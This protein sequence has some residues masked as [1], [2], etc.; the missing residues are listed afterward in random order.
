MKKLKRTFLKVDE[1]IYFGVKKGSSIERYFDK[2]RFSLQNNFYLYI[3]H[4][5][6]P[7]PKNFTV[8][9]IYLDKNFI[10]H[11]IQKQFI[12]QARQIGKAGKIEIKIPVTILQDGKDLHKI[13]FEHLPTT[14][15]S[16]YICISDL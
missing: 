2:T 10:E 6:P 7:V 9:F 16:V 12:L 15:S 14:D 13:I 3:D 4:G 8:S 5:T 1:R 11:I